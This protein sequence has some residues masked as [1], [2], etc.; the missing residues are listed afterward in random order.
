MWNDTLEDLA[1]KKVKQCDFNATETN[2]QKIG[3]ATHVSFRRISKHVS[4]E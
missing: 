4:Y 3:E 1:T 2:S